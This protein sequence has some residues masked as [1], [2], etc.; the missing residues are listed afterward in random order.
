MTTTQELSSAET[1]MPEEEI[2]FYT[3][4][5]PTPCEEVGN[6]RIAY[7]VV[8]YDDLPTGQTSEH[9]T[10]HPRSRDELA[11]EDGLIARIVRVQTVQGHSGSIRVGEVP[12]SYHQAHQRY[13]YFYSGPEW[14]PVT[15]DEQ[16]E[17]AIWA[18]L[19]YVPE[20]GLDVSGAKPKLKKLKP[21]QIRRL[22]NREL[23]VTNEAL[24]RRFL[25]TYAAKK[26]APYIEGNIIDEFVSL[27]PDTKKNLE[28]K[29]AL[30]RA[31]LGQASEV[32]ADPIEKDF[33]RA[34]KLGLIHPKLGS[35]AAQVLYSRVASGN[36][37]K[38]V[39]QLQL[40][41]AG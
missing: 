36:Q 17:Y 10:A 26:G 35:I 2:E 5:E 15:E 28:R 30:G 20:Y 27:N 22:Q 3:G 6:I 13:H 39:N 41:L 9:H 16:A 24:L 4:F 23:K 8:P 34:H 32:V 37:T 25:R 11:I 7:S 19:P 38:L 33:R 21:E 29:Q 40:T 12:Q 18:A 1:Y 31:I 14:L